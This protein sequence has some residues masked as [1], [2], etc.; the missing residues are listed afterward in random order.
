MK[1]S[2]FWTGK[3]FVRNREHSLRNKEYFL[4]NGEGYFGKK[5][6]SFRKEQGFFGN[7]EGSLGKRRNYRFLARMASGTDSRSSAASP[8]R[9][10][11]DAQERSW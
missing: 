6:H 3:C 8:E 2:F 7:R 9:W 5:G 11:T 4:G 1:K 10:L